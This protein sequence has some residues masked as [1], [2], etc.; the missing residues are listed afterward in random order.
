VDI[1]AEGLKPPI[2]MADLEAAVLIAIN[3]NG[4]ALMNS[5]PPLLGSRPASKPKYRALLKLSG[6]FLKLYVDTC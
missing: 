1:E 4:L 5:K 2:S 3:D 6:R